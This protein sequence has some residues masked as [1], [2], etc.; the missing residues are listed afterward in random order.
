MKK[1]YI[2][3]IFLAGFSKLYAQ[4]YECQGSLF[5][6]L[7]TGFQEG[8]ISWQQSEDSSIWEIIPGEND[9]I[10]VQNASQS[11][12]YR[13]MV[14]NENCTS[15]SSVTR[16]IIVTATDAAIAGA[17]QVISNGIVATLSA[18]PVTNGAGSWSILSGSGG[19]I[20]NSENA[21]T[22]FTGLNCGEY[23]L[24]WTVENNPC[25]ASADT[26]T[27]IFQNYPTTAS[28]GNDQVITNS[29]S[30]T[31]S[32]QVATTGT[33]QWSILSGI[34]GSIGV[35]ANA[36]TTFSG[37]NCAS[38]QLLWT[39]E[40]NPCTASVDTLSVIFQYEPSDAIAGQNQ[41]G[42]QMCG[43]TSASLNATAP[44]N[45]VGLWT[46]LSGNGGS[47]SDAS[48]PDAVFSGLAGVSYSLK[49]AITNGNCP[50]KSDTI[51]VRFRQN[52][53]LANAGQDMTGVET[54]GLSS[55]SLS[56][57]APVVGTGTW[58]IVSGN[59]GFSDIYAPD[60]TIIAMS[61][62]S[63]VL[64][65]TVKNDSCTAST[66]QINI[67]FNQNPSQANAGADYTGASTCG[68]TYLT[69]PANTPA[70]GVGVWT[71][72][73]GSGGSFA[74]A[75][76]P[77][78][79]FT[80]IAGT[81]YTLRWTISN[82]PCPASSD[83]ML[84]QFHQNPSAANAGTDQA[85]NGSTVTLAAQSPSV[86]IGNWSILSGTGGTISNPTNPSSGFTGLQGLSYQLIWTGSNAP[87]NSNSDTVTICLFV[88]G[89]PFTDYRDGRTYISLQIGS[90]CW[91]GQ[92]LNIGNMIAANTNQLHNQIYE[93]YC[94]DNDTNQC[95]TWGGLYQWGEMV[96]YL[97][98]ASNAASWNPIPTGYIHGICPTG[99]HL[100]N[101]QE[102]STLTTLNG[103]LGL[104]GGEMK[105]TGTSHW[106][107]PNTGATNN[108]GFSAIPS[109]QRVAGIFQDKSFYAYFWSTTEYSAI[110]AYNRTLRYDDMGILYLGYSKQYGKSV[111]CIRD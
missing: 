110:N 92:N 2:I 44:S 43:L 101:D 25:P 16:I 70:V 42:T 89:N 88:C 59:P 48:L 35:S 81:L 71:I 77:F 86:G 41:N 57:T 28:A 37:Q 50:E 40:N 24:V 52:P 22:T 105:E 90:Q 74:D 1:L 31:I 91:M 53:S 61:G 78:A 109:G 82:A 107:S 34:G 55:L 99:W 62:S 68:I 5:D 47:F 100:P 64:L 6:I 98:G 10:L 18:Q 54:C 67:I 23:Q 111:R 104:A 69:I 85:F 49:W 21:A 3:L 73:N 84:V 36:I 14:V 60:A 15:F 12:Y 32:A 9:T 93:K 96:Q 27:I 38:Y 51:L 87:C 97:N 66:D 7:L 45:G 13:A 58:S 20:E 102:W 75:N 106:A 65:W 19:L 26:I 30:T 46:V 83:D 63:V 8:T 95:N 79:D 72:E 80:G 4:Q 94:Y 29:N 103:G 56:A 108:S 11:L 76:N 39:V 33:G 17:D